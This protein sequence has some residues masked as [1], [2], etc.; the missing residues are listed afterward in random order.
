VSSAEVFARYLDLFTTGDLEGAAALLTDDF[1]FDG[2]MLQA[3]GKDAFLAG[4]SGLGPMVRGN[5]MIRQLEDGEEVCSLYEFRIET[6]LGSGSIP[7]TEWAQVRDGKLASARL[8]FDTAQMA[9]LMP[10]NQ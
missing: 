5:R 1:E 8:I 10:S 4:A 9:A 6:P 2:P 7:M 3:K